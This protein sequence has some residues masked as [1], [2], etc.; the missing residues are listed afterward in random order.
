MPADGKRPPQQ[1]QGLWYER[2]VGFREEFAAEIVIGNA[3][4]TWRYLKGSQK[5]VKTRSGD[6]TNNLLDRALDIETEVLKNAKYVRY[7][8]GDQVVDGQSCMA[9]LLT[10]IEP[11]LDVAVKAEKLGLWDSG[12]LRPP[13]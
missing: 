3:Q 11:Q 7:F 4:G 1:L 8:A 6:D 10:K 12:A 2:G 5:A 13:S 9:Y